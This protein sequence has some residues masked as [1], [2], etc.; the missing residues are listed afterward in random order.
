[1]TNALGAL[2][3]VARRLA[4]CRQLAEAL[5]HGGA[6]AHDAL[7]EHR[8]REQE[9]EWAAV[10]IQAVQRG[11]AVRNAPK[12]AAATKIQAWQ[13]GKAARRRIPGLW[14]TKRRLEVL[15][16]AEIG[17][18]KRGLFLLRHFHVKTIVLPRQA[19]DNSKNCVCLGMRIEKRNAGR[20]EWE[21]GYITSLEPELMVTRD[22]SMGDLY[23]P[24]A[25]KGMSWDDVRLLSAE[26][27][28]KVN[29]LVANALEEQQRQ[30]EAETERQREAAAAAL[31]RSKQQAEAQLQ[32]A[33]AD[34]GLA[35]GTRIG[36]QR[37][38][39]QQPLRTGIY[40]GF[41]KNRTGANEHTMSVERESDHNMM[42][43][44]LKLKKVSENTAAARSICT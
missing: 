18:E 21:E 12:H 24:S 5:S 23:N 10:K 22:C 43:Q 13:R 16:V 44:K 36:F 39:Q 33:Q 6:A 29:E 11:R 32:L 17:K 19:R 9:E 40:K 41:K 4:Q 38:G 30:A 37:D 15:E 20:H 1:M 8:E 7:Q 28:E 27:Q 35:V 3:A 42:V 31:Q 26:R 2:R 25:G 14:R 34:A